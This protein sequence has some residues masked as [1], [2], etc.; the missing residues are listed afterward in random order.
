MKKYLLCG[1]VCL[2]TCVAGTSAQEFP[3]GPTKQVGTWRDVNRAIKKDPWEPGKRYNFVNRFTGQRTGGFIERDIWEPKKRWNVYD[4]EGRNTGRVERDT[5]EDD[6]WN[7]SDYDD[8][9]GEYDDGTGG[10]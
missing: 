1:L 2:A 8:G 7:S 3:T 4:A 9:I 10:D 6:R 5:F